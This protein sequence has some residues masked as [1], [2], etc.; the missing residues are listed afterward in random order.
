MY[1]CSRSKAQ[2]GT[3][4]LW[5]SRPSVT[6]APVLT[7]PGCG[8][9]SR[10]LQMKA[11]D[12]GSSRTVISIPKKGHGRRCFYYP[13]LVKRINKHGLWK[14]TMEATGRDIIMRR[15]LKGRYKLAPIHYWGKPWIPPHK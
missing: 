15:M 9:L 7:S 1:Y 6:K 10:V 5:A 11:C 8:L 3:N 12:V 4:S 2:Y 13:S 14:R